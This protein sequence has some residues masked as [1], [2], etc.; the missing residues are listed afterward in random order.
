MDMWMEFELLIP[1]MQDAE[2]ADRGAQVLGI[3]RYFEQRFRARVKEQ[4][5]DYF[6]VLQSQ[7]SKLVR[8]SEHDMDITHRQ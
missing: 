1:T 3:A 4:I 5:K 7:R 2:E 6:F 8:Q